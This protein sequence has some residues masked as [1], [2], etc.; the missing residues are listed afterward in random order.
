MIGSRLKEL[1]TSRGVSLRTLG[2][3]TGLSATLLSQIERGVTEPSL[4]SMRLLAD[5]FGQSITTLFQD[6]PDVDAPHITRPGERMRLRSGHGQTHYER[7]THG[8]G[9]LEVLHGT[10]L[11]GQSTSAKPRGHDAVECVYVLTGDVTAEVGEDRYVLT[12]GQ[13][14]TI[15]SLTPH[16]YLNVGP[17]RTEFILSVTPPTP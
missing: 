15:N 9:R 14:I 17:E 3:A 1:R 12:A 10:L 16:R 13:A 6:G 8:N 4:K 11:P 7:V 5:Y 2:S